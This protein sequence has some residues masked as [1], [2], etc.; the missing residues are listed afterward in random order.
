MAAFKLLKYWRNT[1]ADAARV[2]IKLDGKT[3][4]TRNCKVDLQS[5]SVDLAQSLQ[6]ID[7][8]EARINYEK[9]VESKDHEDWQRLDEV[10]IL[11]S[12]FHVNPVPEYAKLTGETGPHFPFWIKAILNRQGNLRPDDDT[13]PYIPRTHLEPQINEKVNF[14][15][16]NVDTIDTVFAETF[17]EQSWLAYWNY[18][19]NIFQAITKQSFKTYAIENYS[20]TRENIIIVNNIIKNPAD[21]IIQLYDFLQKQE[22]LPPL[23]Q[24]ICELNDEPLKRLLSVEEFEAASLNHLGQMGHEYPLSASQRRSLYHFKTLG[25]G[26]VLAV[27]GPPG[28]GKTTLLQSIVANEV[29][30]SAIEGGDPRIIVA[31]STN[32]QAVTN[33]ID[34]FYNVKVRQGILYRRWIPIISSFALYLPS[35]SKRVDPKFKYYKSFFDG[36]RT[37]VETD[38]FLTEARKVYCQCF[39]EYAGS[40]STVEEITDILRSKLLKRKD[41]LSVG[42]SLWK[43]FKAIAQHVEHLGADIKILFTNNSLDVDLLSGIESNL[44]SLEKRVSD[45]LDSES[46]WIKLFSFFRFVQEKRATRLKQIFRDC[47]VNYNT[48]D[49]YK[50]VSLHQFFDHRLALIKK[51]REANVAWIDWK[52]RVPVVGN[53]PLNE[54]DFKHRKNNFLYDELEVG[55]KNEMFYLAVH[56]WEGR[57]ILDTE[58]ALAGKLESNGQEKALWRFQ[59]FAMLMPCFVSTFYMAP[60]FFTYSKFIRKL[61]TRNVYESPP[62]LECIDFLIVDEAGQVSPEVGAATFALAKRAIVVGDTK[63]IEPVWSVP[64][65]I[66]HANLHRHGLISS[67]E[68]YVRT[69]ELQDKGFLGSSGSVMML[70]QKSTAFQ[71][72]PKTDRGML[73]TEHRRCFDEIIEYC[74]RLAYDG[75]L[76]RM[77]GKAR[78]VLFEPMKFIPVDGESFTTGSSRANKSEANE[79]A[80]WLSQNSKKIVQ[81]YQERENAEA[82]K[83]NRPAKKIALPEVVGIITPFTGQKWAIKSALNHNG[84]DTNG[85]TIGTVHALQGAE[86]QIILFSTVYG[87][88]NIGGNYFFDRGVNMLNVAVSRAKENFIVFGCPEVFQGN[89]GTPSS[90]LYKHIKGLESVTI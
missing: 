37:E 51:I 70:A 64:K 25:R 89:N 65:K 39:S 30:L 68:D 83:D 15:F 53:P 14:I 8:E 4:C 44:L 45:Y 18:L 38:P 88:N 73:L 17:S 84:I 74:N 40:A 48:L 86:R 57:W 67:K 7:K 75:L 69:A 76:E 61:L 28:T 20:V 31:C 87:K 35:K 11:L 5:G 22:A 82:L 41:M 9:G 50:I 24:R 21:G 72:N 13:F 78:N 10:Q 58:R 42:M 26:D 3:I 23:L 81:H 1:L 43:K 32:N 63:Q 79:I 29:V 2:E 33:I 49:F 47:A 46:I 52:K 16:S 85:L 6:L 54:Q 90:L 66:D 59:R 62:L 19:Q 71:L 34:S 77:K 55:I 36:F 12:A 60:K 80:R 56:Y 27:N